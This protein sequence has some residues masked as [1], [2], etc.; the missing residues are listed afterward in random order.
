MWAVFDNEY[1]LIEKHDGSKELYDLVR[2][3]D[4]KNN[5]ID[6]HPGQAEKLLAQLRDN[7]TQDARTKTDQVD[8][9]LDEELL[10]LLR[11]L[12]YVR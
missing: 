12:D 4:Q 5:L 3:F 7:R 8:V 2:D 6:A 1:Y 9:E 10:E 11:S